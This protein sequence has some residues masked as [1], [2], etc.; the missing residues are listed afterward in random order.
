MEIETNDIASEA[1]TPDI[2][3]KYES[4]NVD[5][6]QDANRTEEL[7]VAFNTIASMI[8]RN[9]PDLGFT[10]S[11][12]GLPIITSNKPTPLDSSSGQRNETEKIMDKLKLPAEIVTPSAPQDTNIKRSL[13]SK[14]EQRDNNDFYI[15]F[16]PL[17]NFGYEGRTTGV[18]IPEV[19]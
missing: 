19:S 2:K 14:F 8:I 13:F 1:S 12:S 4:K 9:N 17:S 11:P 3:G 18:V 10:M 6:E 15:N 5:E 16:E 7:K